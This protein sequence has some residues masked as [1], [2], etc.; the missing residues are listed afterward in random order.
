MLRRA[1]PVGTVDLALT[2]DGLRHATGLGC[3]YTQ[4]SP[5]AGD[6]ELQITLIFA[7][8]SR[9]RILQVSDRQLTDI[10]PVTGARSPA[11]APATKSVVFENRALFGYTGLSKLEGKRTDLWIADVVAEVH[12]GDVMRATELVRV[13]L[14]RAFRRF[15]VPTPIYHA[16]VVSGFRPCAGS[17]LQAFNALIANSPDECNP[18]RT[19]SVEV[20]DVPPGRMA[21]T[22]APL[23]LSDDV[24][25][26]LT[27]SLGRA[28]EHGSTMSAAT[29]LLVRAIRDVAEKGEVWAGRGRPDA[30]GVAY[31]YISP[32]QDSAHFGPT[33]VLNGM[34]SRDVVESHSY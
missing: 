7:L 3:A 14:G 15:R 2:I 26:G 6:E 17:S 33:M 25:T 31:E 10:H 8:A 22:Q 4:H 16:V 27:R 12:D 20:Y 11:R 34:V 24:Y 5:A 28:G 23:W 13:A 9:H 19:F 18:G 30:D 29:D 32:D 21:L 1:L